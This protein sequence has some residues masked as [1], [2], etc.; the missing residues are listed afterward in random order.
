MS[1]DE[2]IIEKLDKIH[3]CLNSIDKYLKYI[4]WISVVS[5]F[6]APFVISAN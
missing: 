6:I 2:Q 3:L 5:L 4:F 1:N